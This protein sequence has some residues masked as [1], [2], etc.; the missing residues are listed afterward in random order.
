MLLNLLKK[1]KKQLAE[2]DKEIERFKHTVDFYKSY[3]LSFREKVIAELEKIKTEIT[4]VFC[5]PGG[6]YSNLH[7]EVFKKIDNQ[8]NLLKE[9]YEKQ[10]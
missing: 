2:K 4:P 6:I 5:I 9:K 10:S 7:N 1:L 3:Y 8:I